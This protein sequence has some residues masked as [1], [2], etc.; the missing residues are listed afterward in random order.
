MEG[1]S[2]TS[3]VL[4]SIKPSNIFVRLHMGRI[5]T[6]HVGD[7]GEARGPHNAAGSS[8]GTWGALACCAAWLRTL[9]PLA[10]SLCQQ[11]PADL[12]AG[13]GG[14]AEYLSPEGFRGE[15]S[16]AVDVYAW[17]LTLW[18]LVHGEM[19][20]GGDRPQEIKMARQVGARLLPALVWVLLGSAAAAWLCLHPRSAWLTASV[21]AAW[22]SGGVDSGAALP[23]RP[24]RAG[25]SCRALAASDRPGGGGPAGANPGLPAAPGADQPAGSGR[26]SVPVTVFPL[27]G[28]AVVAEAW[29]NLTRVVH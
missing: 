27:L 20:G 29:R 8:T 9:L 19:P 17:A 7:W 15:V 12:Y 14:T 28:V 1:G 16:P 25:H 26:R 13:A 5:H 23:G 21:A 11:P 24:V 6:V 3:C 2:D 18:E 10:A 4:C 22:Q